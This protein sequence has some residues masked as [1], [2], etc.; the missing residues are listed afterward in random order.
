[1]GKC[2]KPV[3]CTNTSPAQ[4]LNISVG[5]TDTTAKATGGISNITSYVLVN[6]S[7]TDSSLN[8][9]T[10]IWMVP[11]NGMYNISITMQLTASSTAGLSLVF[12]TGSTIYKSIPFIQA[13]TTTVIASMTFTLML[14]IG[15]NFSFGINNTSGS[16]VSLTSS[17]TNNWLCIYSI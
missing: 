10:G 15:T 4:T 7:Y 12:Y 11:F 2:C 14:P 1:M 8:S 16:S 17:S 6:G 3:F 13:T 5:T 9:S